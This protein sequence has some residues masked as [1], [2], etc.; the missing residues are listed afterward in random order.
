MTAIRN[1]E[2]RKISHRY[3]HPRSN[4]MQ[5]DLDTRRSILLVHISSDGLPSFVSRDKSI[6]EERFAV[7]SI[8]FR[9]HSDALRILRLTPFH[10]AVISWF[11]WDNAFWANRIAGFLGRGSITIAGGF[12]VARIPEIGYGNLIEAGARRRT[13]DALRRASLVLAVSHSIAREAAG[14]AAR[15]D[16]RVVHHGF[17]QREYPFGDAKKTVALTVGDVTVSNLTRKGIRFFVEAARR[18]PD[19]PFLV[20]GRQ[21]A[22]AVRM[23]GNIPRNVTLLGRLPEADLK[24]VMMESKVYVQV[25]AH[26]GFGCSLAEAMLCGCVPVVSDRGAIP[27]V[28]GDT[29]TYIDPRNAES[30]AE[31]VDEAMTRVATGSLARNRIATLF[32]LERRRRL[33]L[34]AVEKVLE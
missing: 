23:L 8:P 28:V 5:S 29:G 3:T 12:D 15:D 24:R 13:R 1:S 9:N 19:I 22:K 21:D 11:A 6:L 34:G 20:I 18:A 27:E 10:D 7:T 17:D 30:V 4:G 16:V 14:L 26:E 31:G 25:S 33:L 2:D 32:P